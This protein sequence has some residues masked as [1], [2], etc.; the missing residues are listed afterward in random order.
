MSVPH[1]PSGGESRGPHCLAVADAADLAGALRTLAVRAHRAIRD[2][3]ADASRPAELRA[4]RSALL[5]LEADLR[6]QGLD[7]LLPYVR[8]LRHK[9]ED[10][11]G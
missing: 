4:L 8:A 7:G 6:G 9:I 5:D 1:H 2:E 3:D 11:L 10:R